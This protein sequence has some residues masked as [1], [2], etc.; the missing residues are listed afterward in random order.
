[1]NS[2]LYLNGAHVRSQ[3]YVLWHPNPN[4]N[5]HP[6]PSPKTNQVRVLAP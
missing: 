2:E 6:N 3:P 5:P 4:P 1:M